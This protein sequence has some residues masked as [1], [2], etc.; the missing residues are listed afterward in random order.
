MQLFIYTKVDINQIEKCFKEGKAIKCLVTGKQEMPFKPEIP[1]LIQDYERDFLLDN[2][3]DDSR[4]FLYKF[5]CLCNDE[6]VEMAQDEIHLSQST[7]EIIKKHAGIE[8][9]K[10]ST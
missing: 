4:D 8:A 6:D 1:T 2:P 5:S 10:G 7:R 9:C 3:D